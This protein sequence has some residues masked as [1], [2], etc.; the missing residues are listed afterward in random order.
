M[1]A[2]L[3]YGLAEYRDM[4][5]AGAEF[6]WA[7]SQFVPHGGNHLNLAATAAFGLGRVRGLSRR[8]SS[9]SAWWTSGRAST[10]GGCALP[11]VPG[12]RAGA[13]SRSDG[14]DARRRDVRQRSG[15][16]HGPAA[17]HAGLGVCVAH[18]GVLDDVARL[19]RRAVRVDRR[20]GRARR[21]RQRRPSRRHGRADA[22]RLRG[23]QGPAGRG[24]RHDA[25]TS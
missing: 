14:G 19:A 10:A 25:R 7:R 24:G 8:S 1:D 9:R 6:G 21:R 20:P 5:E 18:R 13:S 12:P 3:G 15:G 22:I 17:T 4:V 2:V 23:D 11:D 16:E